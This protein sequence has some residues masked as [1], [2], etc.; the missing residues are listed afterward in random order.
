MMSPLY[1]TRA[2]FGTLTKDHR[3]SSLARESREKWNEMDPLKLH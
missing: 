1:H 3:I 2:S